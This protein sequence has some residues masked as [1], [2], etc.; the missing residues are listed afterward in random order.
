MCD[1]VHIFKIIYACLEAYKVAFTHIC[2]HI[3]GL[4]ACFLKSE[5][6]GQL[7]AALGKDG[8]NH[9]YLI[10][11]DVVEVETRDSWKWFLDLLLEYLNNIFRRS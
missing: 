11:Y 7:M 6:G 10:S 4:D 2:R 3:I 9:I 5:Y 1:I 8:N